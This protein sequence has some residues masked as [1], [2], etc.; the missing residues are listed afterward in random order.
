M[1]YERGPSSSSFYLSVF[2]IFHQYN[3]T[4]YNPSAIYL[5]EIFIQK[6]YCLQRAITLFHYLP[7]PPHPV[8]AFTLNVPTVRYSTSE[9]ICNHLNC[10][11]LLCTVAI[12]GAGYLFPYVFSQ[13]EYPAT[14][15]CNHFVVNVYGLLEYTAWGFLLINTH[16]LSKK[17]K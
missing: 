11:S 15:P 10:F 12:S 5:F 4:F 14:Q 7:S 17:I 6:Y 3:E 9:S 1:L 13:V 8:E 2:T 16:W